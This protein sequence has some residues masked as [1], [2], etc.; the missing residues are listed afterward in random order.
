MKDYFSTASD[1]YARFRPTYPQELFDFLLQLCNKREKAWDCGTGSGQVAGE[2]AN[3]FDQ[4]YATDISINQ[5]SQGIQKENIHYSKQAAE[6]TVFPD[7]AF[8][9]VTVGQAVHWFDFEL[10]YGEVKR[11][12][13]REAVIAIFGYALFNSTPGTNK[14]IEDFYHNII[15]TFWPQERR[16]LEERY[17]TIPFPFHEI[18]APH[19]E[20]KQQW[21]FERLV[22]YL[23][24]WSAV[25][26]YESEK[27]EN[28]VEIIEQELFQSF[29][30]VGPV[31]FPV[32]LRLGRI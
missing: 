18:E 25:K 12:L 13:K 5:L 31:N 28:P 19:F 2:L 24:T 22:G 15:G 6:N 7:A 30:E 16:Y 8:D 3:S 10:F 29:G 17:Q 14:I 32:I 11:V 4:V 27:G 23:K 26:L 20:M 21:S 9:L 1:N